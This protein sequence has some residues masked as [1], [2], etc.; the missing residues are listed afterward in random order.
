MALTEDIF[1]R[2]FKAFRTF[3]FSA[4][5]HANFMCRCIANAAFSITW[6]GF[7]KNLATSLCEFCLEVAA[8]SS[9]FLYL[10]ENVCWW[11]GF[12]IHLVLDS[13]R[14][15]TNI[16]IIPSELIPIKITR[17]NRLFAQSAMFCQNISACFS[18]C[19]NI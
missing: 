10:I 13:S 5:S 16:E 14:C 11:I 4:L 6:H 2:L 8:Y 17:N 12:M 18:F 15:V 9:V 19:I 3:R 1:L 7:L